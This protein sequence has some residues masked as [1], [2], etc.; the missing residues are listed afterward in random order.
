MAA[1]LRETGGRERSIGAFF[2][3]A[4][5]LPLIAPEAVRHSIVFCLN[6]GGELADSYREAPDCKRRWNASTVSVPV[7][8]SWRQRSKVAIPCW[9]NNH[10][11]RGAAVLKPF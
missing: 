3:L 8:K 5:N 11:R 1:G 10:V 9:N 7:R 4:P 6:E 2:P